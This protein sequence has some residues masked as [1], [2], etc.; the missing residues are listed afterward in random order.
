[1]KTPEHTDTEGKQPC[2]DGSRGQS[3]TATS[4]RT[5][6]VTRIWENQGRR[7]QR[8]DAPADS[9]ILGFQPPEL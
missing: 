7:F 6:G 9:L 1:M 3:D 2:E 4:H 8:E 5:P